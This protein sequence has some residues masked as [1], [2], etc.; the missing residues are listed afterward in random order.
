M[1]SAPSPS[2]AASPA[3]RLSPSLSAPTIC[4]SGGSKSGRF[5]E[6]SDPVGGPRIPPGFGDS[7]P[8]REWQSALRTSPVRRYQAPYSTYALLEPSP[9]HSRGRPKRLVDMPPAATGIGRP[10][11]TSVLTVADLI[12]PSL[13]RNS[14]PSI[15]NAAPAR[16]ASPAASD[17]QDVCSVASS[18]EQRRPPSFASTPPRA[19]SPTFAST[20]P[21]TFGS[22][23]L[24]SWKSFEVRDYSPPGMRD[25]QLVDRGAMAAPAAVGGRP[26]SHGRGSP[27]RL[28]PTGSNSSSCNTT[29]VYGQHVTTTAKQAVADSSQRRPSFTGKLADA[30]VSKQ[31]TALQS[32]S[33]KQGGAAQSVAAASTSS[34]SRSRPSQ[35]G[36]LLSRTQHRLAYAQS[37]RLQLTS[38]PT[39]PV[40]YGQEGTPWSP[41][42]VRSLASF[43]I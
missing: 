34:S 7:T 16:A 31:G 21:E 22:N 36:G 8:H 23:P 40:T 42:R 30:E 24:G 39:G 29:H 15:Y 9:P 37:V 10:S 20:H 41:A 33:A 28:Q 4:I 12:Q 11:P 25:R 2:S 35:S 17:Q 6:M 32:T 1:R 18:K 14:H 3:Y 13:R 19:I 5:A 27:T 43:V 38:P 26:K